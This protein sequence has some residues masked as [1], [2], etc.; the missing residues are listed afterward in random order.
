MVRV[1]L[2][3]VLRSAAPD[4]NGR[5]FSVS[6]GTVADLLERIAAA[7]PVGF[8]ARLFEGPELRRYLSV[9][10]DGRDIR[11]TGGLT[12]PVDRADRVDLLPAVAGG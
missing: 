10:V 3:S 9:Y 5:E 8:R 12:T 11:F 2:G 7:G 4:L 1:F 6:A